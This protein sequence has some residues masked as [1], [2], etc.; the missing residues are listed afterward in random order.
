M[1]TIFITGASTGLGKATAKLFA[2]KGW[3]V[4]ATMRKPETEREL[5]RV[6]NITLLPL[7]VT[8]LEQINS[9]AQ[10]AIALGNIDV[11][12]NNAGY[13]L[14]GPM[15]PVTDEQLTRQINTNILGVIRVTQAFIPYFR[16]KKNGLFMTTTSM[17]GLLTFPLSS[18]YHATKWALEGWSE[19][20]AFE[21]NQFG[22]GV[23]TVS[24]GG[25]KTDFINR[26]LDTTSHP[27]YLK[28]TEKLYAGIHEDSFSTAEQIAE[29]VYEAATD[30]KDKLRYVAGADAE[31][32]YAQR[33]QLGDEAFRKGMAQQF[34]GVE[35]A[36]AK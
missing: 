17:G 13:G 5:N 3:K 25:I 8:N 9:T 2:S 10:K 1:K 6:D 22:I 33:L 14:I 12:F 24:P 30:G 34:F 35:M 15:E 16:E 19:S 11:V 4:I 18:V 26:S 32:L 20:L 28:L 36:L 23:K 7:D 21:L 31:A 29:I 27:A